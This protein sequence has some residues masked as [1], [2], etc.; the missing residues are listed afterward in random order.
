MKTQPILTEEDY[1][2]ALAEILDCWNAPEDSEE[3]KRLD[4]LLFRVALYESKRSPIKARWV[5]HLIPEIP[6]VLP[7]ASAVLKIAKIAMH[8]SLGAAFG[9]PL[10]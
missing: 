1:Q 2:A 6:R 8:T 4:F 9:L 3:G 5:C 10:R 7:E